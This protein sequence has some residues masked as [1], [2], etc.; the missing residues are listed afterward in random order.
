M[1]E[2]NIDTDT[3]KDREQQK[4]GTGVQA[5]TDKRDE[6][7]VT[8]DEGG[9]VE[10]KTPGPGSRRGDKHDL[11]LQDAELGTPTKKAVITI[12]DG[13]ITAKVE[14]SDMRKGREALRDM[15]PEHL[16]VLSGAVRSETGTR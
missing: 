2:R 14:G 7:Q 6:G 8:R 11:P 4:Q 13:E 1:A 15:D 10:Y 9:A 3:K 5:A 16:L 12:E